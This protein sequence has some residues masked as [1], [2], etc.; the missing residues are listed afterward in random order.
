MPFPRPAL[1][2][3]DKRLIADIEARLPG[4]DP[5]VRRS[6]LGALAR[7][8]AGSHH[9]LYGFLEWISRQRFVATADRP[10]LLEQAAEYGIRPIAAVRATGE[11][12]VTG[13]AATVIAAATVWRSGA[14]EDYR[15]TAEATIGAGGT[16]D[17][18]VEAV[19]PGADGNAVAG[20]KLSL[21]SP[22]AGV[23]SAAT[24]GEL[25]GGA[26]IES[27]DSVR[28]RL[29]ARKQNPPQGGTSPDY[30]QWAKAAHADVTRRW[31]RPLAGGL[32]TVTVYFMTDDATA[33]GIPSAAV[34]ATVQA[35]ID[36]RRPVTADVTV[37]AP[38]AVEFDVTINNVA[39][40]TQAVQDAVTAEIA[41][42]VL[43]ASE[44]GGTIL[45]SHLR[46][47]ISTAAGETDHVLVSPVADVVVSADE[48]SVEGA[49]TFTTS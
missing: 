41:D 27:T 8:L 28:E 33:D 25:G 20:T 45:V 23:V 2:D 10:E 48:I 39:P 12:A 14:P 7:G 36:A 15:S 46:E 38:T 13:T 42:L 40:M 43:R 32:G 1:D 29:A 9:E 21:V 5:R 24:A 3:L 17:V 44:P 30:E 49:V 26:D 18:A 34:V 31:S 37:E 19:E 47:A 35:Y 6:Y 16:V 22:I 11:I 4:T